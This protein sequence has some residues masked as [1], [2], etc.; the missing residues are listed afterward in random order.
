MRLDP[1]CVRDILLNLES[2]DFAVTTNIEKLHLTLPQYSEEVISYTCFKLIEA[3]YI[4]AIT[5]NLLRQTMPGIKQITC[6]TFAGHEFLE[7]VRD[8]SV[9]SEVKEKA[10]SVKS[11]ALDIISQIAV[12]VVTKRL[13]L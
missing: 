6:M 8:D 11:F 9:W 3:D 2:L 13:G 1:N 5:V 4:E 7:N 12:A 10:S